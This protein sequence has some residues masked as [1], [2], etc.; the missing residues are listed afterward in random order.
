MSLKKINE[1]IKKLEYIQKRGMS[2]N[3][4]RNV[5]EDLSETI[6]VKNREVREEKIKDFRRESFDK[7]IEISKSVFDKHSGSCGTW[8]RKII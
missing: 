1:K 4:R 6:V 5:I 3:A 7:N 2:K 8:R